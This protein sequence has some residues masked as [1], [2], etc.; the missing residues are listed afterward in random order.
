MRCYQKKKSFVIT[1]S[2]KRLL[3]DAGLPSIGS[4]PTKVH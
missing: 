4:V 2:G 1:F 3:N